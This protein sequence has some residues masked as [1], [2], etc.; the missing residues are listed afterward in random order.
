MMIKTAAPL[1]GLLAALLLVSQPAAA[2]NTARHAL[3]PE[4]RVWVEG[5]S[6]REVWS[7]ESRSVEGFVVFAAGSADGSRIQQGRFS[8]GAASLEGGRGPIMDRLMHGALK[9]G[10]HP[11]IVYELTSTEPTPAGA[12]K[13]RL[14][15]GGRTTIAGITREVEGSVEVERLDNGMLRFSGSYPLQMSDYG[16]TPPTAMFGALRTGDRVVVHFDLRVRP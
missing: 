13:Y 4:S 16:I 14:T 15:T 7:V 12:G 10:E 3:L 1:L 11:Q 5:T 6:N 2:Q 9:S 8:L